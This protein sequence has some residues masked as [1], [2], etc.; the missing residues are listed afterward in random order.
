MKSWRS[1]IGVALA[2]GAAAVTVPLTA[3]TAVAAP[4]PGGGWVPI[5][6]EKYPSKAVC[7]ATELPLAQANGYHEVWCDDSKE[8]MPIFNR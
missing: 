6:A 1:R 4:P 3:A 8:I 7:E 5:G 2:V